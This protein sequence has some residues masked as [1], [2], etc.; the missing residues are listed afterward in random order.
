MP[1]PEQS[2]KSDASIVW[3]VSV[4]NCHPVTERIRAP[5]TAQRSTVQFRKSSRPSWYRALPYRTL[6]QIE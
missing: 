5:S 3:R 4:V 6:S 1:S 2:A